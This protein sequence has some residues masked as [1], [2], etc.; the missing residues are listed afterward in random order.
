[1]Y[2]SFKK[3]KMIKYP[4]MKW[5]SPL[6][7]QKQ[8]SGGALLTQTISLQIFKRLQDCKFIKKETLAQV[9][10]CAFCEISKK[11]FYYRT[12]LVAASVSSNDHSSLDIIRLIQREFQ[13]SWKT[14]FSSTF[15]ACKS[16]M[17]VVM[18]NVIVVIY[19]FLTDAK[20]SCSQ[21]SVKHL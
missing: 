2:V 10:S 9:F 18:C 3:F 21:K 17:F 16:K 19:L 20:K 5:V 13:F 8:S 11:T 15:L 7:L 4:S 12:P 6:S 14:M 1:M